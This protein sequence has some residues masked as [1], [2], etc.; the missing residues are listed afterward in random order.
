[1]ADEEVR[2]FGLTP[3]TRIAHDQERQRLLT[4][5]AEEG[6]RHGIEEGRREGLEFLRIEPEHN[7]TMA[8]VGG[9]I[10]P[11]LV[12]ALADVTSLATAL[13]IPAICYLLI[14]TYGWSARNPA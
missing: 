13:V 9:A 8:I 4:G 7:G 11:L 12:G 14:A 1:M 6:R 10:V 5:A 3:R 2:R